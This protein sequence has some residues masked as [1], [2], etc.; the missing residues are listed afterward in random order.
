[1]HRSRTIL[2]LT[3]ALVVV[4]VAC[5]PSPT[6]TPTI[7]PPVP[8]PTS[9]VPTPA[10]G[11][12]ATVAHVVDGDTA[13]LADGRNV[14]YIGINT[15]EHDQPFYK[16]ATDLNLRLVE[17]KEVTLGFDLDT[18]D[19]YG[20][21]LAYVFAGDVFVN[22]EIVRQGYASVYTVPPNVKYDREFL[23]AQREAREAERGLWAA[24]PS[25]LEITALQADA[26]GKDEENPNGE[27]VEITNQGETALRL[28]GF[29]LKDEANHVYT[30]PEFS[31][32]PGAAV[33]L[34]SG[35]GQNTNTE[36]YWGL[37]GESVWN[38]DGDTAFLRDVHGNLVDVYSY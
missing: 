13:E 16:E 12:R 19:Q 29:T 18:F 38:N 14:R 10:N 33:R 22:L 3:A 35:P 32:A 34:L 24:A 26:P 31:L 4:L 28:R 1:M 27:W 2:G 30:F 20:R 17:G 8:P 25:E 5:I 37:V 23:A 9:V 11:Q 15:P 36:L 21:T 6:T 7:P